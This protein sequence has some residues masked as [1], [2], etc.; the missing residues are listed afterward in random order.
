MASA[1]AARFATTPDGLPAEK[2]VGICWTCGDAVYAS[3]E[4]VWWCPT[5]LPA[6]NAYAVVDP[7]D[8]AL[9]ERSGFYGNCRD[10]AG[11]DLCP[12]EHVPQHGRCYDRY[13]AVVEVTR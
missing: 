6:D 10:E 5:D 11:E 1:S 4:P 7:R 9:M 3:E 8:E 2:A 13:G 12:Y